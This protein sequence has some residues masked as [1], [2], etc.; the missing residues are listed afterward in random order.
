MHLYFLVAVVL[1]LLMIVVMI[2]VSIRLN[3]EVQMAYTT[4]RRMILF[5][6]SLDGAANLQ[7]EYGKYLL[8]QT[9]AGE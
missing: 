6:S 7:L 3:E 4:S 5:F 1:F 9:I 8:A 2:V